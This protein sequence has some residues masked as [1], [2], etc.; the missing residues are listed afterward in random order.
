MGEDRDEVITLHANTYPTA[1]GVVGFL[2]EAGKG[3][4]VP[5]LEEAHELVQ[6]LAEEYADGPFEIEW[7]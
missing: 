4:E 7:L 3:A 1:T 2:Q 6:T 5:T